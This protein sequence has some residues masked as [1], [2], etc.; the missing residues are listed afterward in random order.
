[1]KREPGKVDLDRRA[2]IVLGLAGASALVMG[3]ANGA[4]AQEGR[5][6]E[7]KVLKEGVSVIPGL[8]KVRLRQATFQPGGWRKA[9]MMNS[10]ICEITQGSLDSKADG[11]PVVRKTGDIYTCKAGQVIESVNN[12]KTVAIMRIFDLLPA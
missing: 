3:K 12:G 9:T 6:V 7:V 5:G 4:F 10:M 8:P 11:E 1:M 2:V